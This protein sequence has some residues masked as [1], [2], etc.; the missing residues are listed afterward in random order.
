MSLKHVFNFAFIFTLSLVVFASA[1][2]AFAQF[3]DDEDFEPYYS[4]MDRS[5]YTVRFLRNPNE[6]SGKFTMRVT[7]PGTL[8]GC[9]TMSEPEVTVKRSI[10]KIKIEL[11]DSEI[12]LKD[13]ET[14]YGNYMCD[15]ET[16]TAYFE[17][18]L[19]RDE[20]IENKVESIM[21][22]SEKYG[23][24]TED[25]INVTKERIVLRTLYPWGVEHITYW[26]YPEN[27]VIL[28]VPKAK[29]GEDVKPLIHAF[30]EQRGLVPMEDIL[31]GF[32][33]PYWANA[34]MYF[35]DPSGAIIRQLSGPGG[36]EVVGTITTQH[37][38]HTR[39]GEI[40]QTSTLDVMA[41]KP[42]KN[43]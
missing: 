7:S 6:G 23:Q 4:L 27:T 17:V 29:A 31:D 25:K 20:L 5:Y 22:D 34:M 19:D 30:A 2:P 41:R 1:N 42:G 21:I 16:H 40:M 28:H 36:N 11:V 26:F 43:D 3:E 32:E 9:L 10:K 24:F 15:K 37:P 14:H 33:L 39:N 8:S 13:D 38:I 35:T 12:E 18:T